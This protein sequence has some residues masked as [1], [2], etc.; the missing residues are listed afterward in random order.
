MSVEDPCDDT[1]SDAAPYRGPDRRQSGGTPVSVEVASDVDP[2]VPGVGDEKQPE[3]L[4]Q[5]ELGAPP[6]GTAAQVVHT[7]EHA[8]PLRIPELGGTAEH[9]PPVPTP[10]PA[11]S[12]RGW[13]VAI[14]GRMEDAAIIDRFIWLCGGS[15]ARLLII[16]TASNQTDTGRWY[17]RLFLRHGAAR[18]DIMRLQ[19]RGDH[20]DAKQLQ[21]LADATGV[22]FTGGNQLKLAT[23]IIGTPLAERLHARFARGMPV[24]GT[25]AGA[26]F[27]SAHM[28]AFGQEGGVPHAGMVTTCGGLGLTERFIIDQHFRERDR[29]GRLLTAVAYNPFVVGLGVDENTAVFISPD[30][31]LEVVGEGAVTVVDPEDLDT[32][33][34]LEALPGTPLE[35]PGMRVSLIEAGGT[36]TGHQV[37]SETAA[38][39]SIR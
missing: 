34:I 30:D 13:L 26:A 7:R 27:L 12:S 4:H 31:V 24:A 20:V 35:L 32:S 10:V 36:H 3:P 19:R 18:A 23:C 15:A 28:I 25:S 17:Q 11:I 5:E 14:G 29:L 21:T 1:P 8:P 9:R 6:A 16:P 37:A 33:H 38:G 39:Q 22:F 2:L